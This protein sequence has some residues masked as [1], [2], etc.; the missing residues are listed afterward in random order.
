MCG[1]VRACV[2]VGMCMCVCV[3][4]CVCMCVCVCVCVCVA[5][6][7]G[8]VRVCMCAHV[9]VRAPVCTCARG[10]CATWLNLSSIVQVMEQCRDVY[11]QRQKALGDAT[12]LLPKPA[13]AAPTSTAFR[14]ALAAAKQR[15]GGAGSPTK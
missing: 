2:R 5:R 7:C 11:L 12:P 8:R 6:V 15:V 14:V 1:C 3:C 13:K 10:M 4:V 9:H